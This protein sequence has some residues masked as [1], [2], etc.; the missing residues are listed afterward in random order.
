MANIVIVTLDVTNNV[1][2]R[3]KTALENKGHTVTLQVQT[4]AVAA[5]FSAYDVVVFGRCTL[6]KADARAV[7]N[8]GK[9]IITDA[10][11]NTAEGTI[12]RKLR[13]LAN[14]VTIVSGASNSI[15]V[16]NISH[17]LYDGL[18]Y[19]EGQTV[20]V[21]SGTEN[22]GNVAFSYALQPTETLAR[23]P[24]GIDCAYAFHK[25]ALDYDGERLPATVIM[26]GW[27]YP[28]ATTIHANGEN[29]LHNAVLWAMAAE[30]MD[31][32]LGNIVL[33]GQSVT[34]TTVVR[35]ANAIQSNGVNHELGFNGVGYKV[36]LVTDA[37][38]LT[39]I[40]ALSTYDAIVLARCNLSQADKLTIRGY[41]K[42]MLVDSAF[43]T[44]VHLNLWGSQGALNP[45]S[46]ILTIKNRDHKAHWDYFFGLFG[47]G[48]TPTSIQSKE[49][50]TGPSS[51][52]DSIAWNTGSFVGDLLFTVNGDDTKPCG[53]AIEEGTNDLAA[54]PLPARIA[55][56]GWAQNVNNSHY[57]IEGKLAIAGAVR[58]ILFDPS[59][60]G[61]GGDFFMDWEETDVFADIPYGGTPDDRLSQSPHPRGWA[62]THPAR[63]F[64]SDSKPLDYLDGNVW[65]LT[66]EDQPPDGYPGNYVTTRPY[67]EFLDNA[68]LFT[69]PYNAFPYIVVGY[70]GYFYSELNDDGTFPFRLRIGAQSW[71]SNSLEVGVCWCSSIAGNPIGHGQPNHVAYVY[72]WVSGE[73]SHT[74]FKGYRFFIEEVNAGGVIIAITKNTGTKNVYDTPTEMETIDS[75]YDNSLFLETFPEFLGGQNSFGDYYSK[76]LYLD[77]EWDP[78]IGR[79]CCW[80]YEVGDP[81]PQT[82]IF[83]YTDPDPL[84]PGEQGF[85]YHEKTTDKRVTS[86]YAS[87]IVTG[88]T[89]DCGCYIAGE[90]LPSG[91]IVSEV[92]PDAPLI[93]PFS[94]DWESGVTERLKYLT[95]IVVAEDDS[96]QRI[97]LRDIPNRIVSFVPVMI[98]DNEAEYFN[99]LMWKSTNE[100]W[101]VP[102]W[103]DVVRLTANVSAGGLV[104]PAVSDDF[105]G[106]ALLWLNSRR[107]EL[108]T[109]ESVDPTQINLVDALVNDWPAGTVIIPLKV[110]RIVDSKVNRVSAAAT[111]ASIS[112]QLEVV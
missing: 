42:P 88:C 25:G 62:V 84:P 81:R 29:I 92:A 93:F 36:T 30:E 48:Q 45:S 31:Y 10:V 38:A 106:E 72:P 85:V 79:M 109:V 53:H 60:I 27:M 78:R 52:E 20:Q 3:I 103:M 58:W 18:G 87:K 46:P 12:P 105:S 34:D 68:S 107:W 83:V 54:V 101:H 49:F 69:A 37:N 70:S 56:C 57:H 35:L 76:H 61:G 21:R 41:G 80:A 40:P 47:A 24:G 15:T 89:V 13:V 22:M 90:A 94:P 66:P 59:G 8:K 96:E 14:D 102:M 98:D 2:V 73:I 9:P 23:R 71:D 19:T 110:G 11:A 97:Q 50:G 100:R 6:S 112:F 82:P 51:G 28:I 86:F 5:D 108:V 32:S 4:G 99:S 64:P 67:Y 91:D 43:S 44:A 7:M 26:L 65:E 17:P 75:I 104:L 74:W 55:V 39:A 111:S 77:V 1:P 33:V 95:D 16:H 63:V